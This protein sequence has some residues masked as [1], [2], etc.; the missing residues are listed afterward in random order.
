MYD[1]AYSNE[2]Y[3]HIG[4]IVFNAYVDKANNNYITF[5]PIESFFGSLSRTATDQITKKSIFI[6][7]IV[8]GQ[9]HYINVFSNIN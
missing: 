8:N 2:Y 5:E 1:N 4:I 7:N 6:D 9:S 3:K